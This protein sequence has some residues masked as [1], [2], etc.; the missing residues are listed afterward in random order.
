[1]S[2]HFLERFCS[3]AII[4]VVLSVHLS[5][6]FF[7]L[8]VMTQDK[9]IKRRDKIPP[10]SGDIW[11]KR[12]FLLADGFVLSAT[13]RNKGTEFF[14]YALQD[15]SEMSVCYCTEEANTVQIFAELHTQHLCSMWQYF[16]TY[17]EVSPQCRV[18]KV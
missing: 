4:C 6:S 18:L 7:S 15:F 3:T 17:S 9:S 10:C 14:K 2:H 11:W 12:C 1:V 13:E 16:Y 8:L 5:S